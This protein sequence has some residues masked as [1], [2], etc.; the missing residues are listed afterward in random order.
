MNLLKP[1]ILFRS[2]LPVLS[3]YAISLCRL[4]YFKSYCDLEQNHEYH[5]NQI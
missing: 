3:L 2:R 1:N 4:I 5:C